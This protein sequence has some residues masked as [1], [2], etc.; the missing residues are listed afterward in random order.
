MKFVNRTMAYEEGIAPEA[1]R[2]EAYKLVQYGRPRRC[3]AEG[4]ML[5]GVRL[6]NVHAFM[7]RE[8]IDRRIALAKEYAK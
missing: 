7:T 3:R 2:C 5:N 1:V 6:C 8:E 4:K